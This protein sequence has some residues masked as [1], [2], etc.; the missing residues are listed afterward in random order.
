L[1][2]R[3]SAEILSKYQ[4]KERRQEGREEER[5]RSSSLASKRE[6]EYKE[7]LDWIRRKKT[8]DRSND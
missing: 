2:G 5:I 8:N 7:N 4:N 6:R 3:I 1:H